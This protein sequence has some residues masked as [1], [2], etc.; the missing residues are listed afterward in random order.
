ML[1][2]LFYNCHGSLEVLKKV[3]ERNRLKYRNKWLIIL[4]STEDLLS[5][6]WENVAFR[7][8]SDVKLVLWSTNNIV[9]IY[10]VYNT[11]YKKNGSLF[12]DYYG[13]WDERSDILLVNDSLRRYHRKSVL[14]GVVLRSSSVVSIKI[15]KI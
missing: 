1:Y 6:T 2:V 12:R 14:S 7:F 4:N 11:G 13:R 10:D 15:H 5:T 8:D 3:A 9:R